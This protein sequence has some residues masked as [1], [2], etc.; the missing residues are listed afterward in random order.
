[1]KRFLSYSVIFLIL[2]LTSCKKNT[3][4]IIEPSPVP[5]Y[6]VEFTQGENYKTVRKKL[7]FE[8]GTLLKGYNDKVLFSNEDLSNPSYVFE[9]EGASGKLKLVLR[10]ED[11]GSSEITQFGFKVFKN[12]KQVLTMNQSASGN[13]TKEY[14][15]SI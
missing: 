4:P 14:L 12:G 8:K 1:M 2:I 11:N 13:A 5:T 10:I 7:E 3:D 9:T 6:K 15:I